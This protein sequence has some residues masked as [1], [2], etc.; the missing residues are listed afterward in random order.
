[1]VSITAMLVTHGAIQLAL[2][3]DIFLGNGT[4]ESKS[5][6]WFQADAT[7][8]VVAVMCVFIL[9]DLVALSLLGQLLLFHLRLRRD[10]LTTYGF[11]VQDNQRKREE[12]KKIRELTQKR[13][14]AVAQAREEGRMCALLHLRVGGYVRKVCGLT[15]CDPLEF[16]E[17]KQDDSKISNGN[18]ASHAHGASNGNGNGEESKEPV[19]EP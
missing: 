19:E 16:T 10:G 15:C 6:D 17:K 18:G 13:V 1:M 7:I 2:V 14:A 4:S 3:L 8:A 5:E 11:I 9:F 12:S